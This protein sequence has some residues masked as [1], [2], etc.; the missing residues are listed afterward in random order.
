MTTMFVE[1]RLPSP[2]PAKYPVATPSKYPQCLLTVVRGH[3]LQISDLAK[4]EE[5]GKLGKDLTNKFTTLL[6]TR[7]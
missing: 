6:I 5:K 4:M 7:A 2:E 3:F 1:Q